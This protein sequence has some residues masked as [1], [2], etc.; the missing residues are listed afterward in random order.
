MP[1]RRAAPPF[2]PVQPLG[3]PFRQFL[4]SLAIVRRPRLHVVASS[5][6]QLATSSP[7]AV[8]S[9]SPRHP[10]GP[11]DLPRRGRRRCWPTMRCRS[12]WW[13]RGDGERRHAA[14]AGP[15]FFLSADPVRTSRRAA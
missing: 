5:R 9:A 10:P 11:R 14:T 7:A 1:L 3:L 2:A 8:I 6:V 12:M 15:G 4:E 13:S